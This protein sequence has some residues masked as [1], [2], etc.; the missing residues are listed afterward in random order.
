MDRIGEHG[1]ENVGRVGTNWT[2]HLYPTR[3]LSIFFGYIELAPTVG[4]TVIRK[5]RSDI[6][7]MAAGPSFFEAINLPKIKPLN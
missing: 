7:E 1:L 3:I 5:N 2:K 4:Y 6:T